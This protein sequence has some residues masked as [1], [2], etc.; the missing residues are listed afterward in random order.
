VLRLLGAGAG[1]SLG[2]TGHALAGSDG[3]GTLRLLGEAGVAK[4]HETVVQGNYAYVATGDR[5]MSVV[6]WGNPVDPEVVAEVD[7]AADLPQSDPTLDVKDVKVDGD[8]AAL[9]ND[10]EDPGGIALYD[11]SDP[12]TPEFR[13]FYAPDPPSNIHNCH[14]ADGHAYLSLGEPENTDT[15]GDGGRDLVRIFGDA[16]VEIV[17][18]S[19]PADPQHAAT[20]LLKEEL[21][22]YAKAGVNPCHD[23]YTQDG[24]C[25]AAF[26]DAGTVA[27]DVSDPTDPTF[28]SQFGAAPEGD[29]EIRPWNTNEE[30]V[31]EYFDEVFPFGRYL[32]PPGNAHYVQP[33]PDG[34]HVY[35]G[36]E[37][38]LGDPGGIDVWDVSDLTS[39][40]QVGRIDPPD[41]D[42]FRTSHNFDVTAN[43]LHASWYAGGVRV[44]D[45]TDPSDPV[46]RAHY[47]PDGYS[48][49]TAE[50][51][52]GYTIGGVYGALSA[53]EGG[54]VVLSDDRGQKRPPAFDG[55]ASPEEPGTMPEDGA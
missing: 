15:D 28:V 37:T 24:I 51:G 26:W 19:D 21:P 31:E 41:V 12:S 52:R 25:Y 36:A 49:W 7:L 35:V 42:A 29:T 39:P 22:E 38:F 45:V 6:D 13:S 4:A 43:R 20:W 9:A 8:V 44:Y 50:S 1:V 55:A 10:T 11:V 14:L 27:L 23:L 33:S 16:G 18:V 32:G 34:D 53:N 5:G 54:I 46:E 47:D 3:G 48:F 17:D 2:A 40:V 30:S